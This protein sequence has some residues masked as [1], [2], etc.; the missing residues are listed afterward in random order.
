MTTKTFKNKI[1]DA[2]EDG[3]FHFILQNE[4]FNKLIS[5][6]HLEDSL[7][8]YFSKTAHI[9]NEFE[10]RLASEYPTV[11]IKAVRVNQYFLKA[12]RVPFLLDLQLADEL[13][14]HQLAWI[15]LQKEELKL[16]E[17][18]ESALN[19]KQ[20][21]VIKLTLPE[22]LVSCIR[23]IED[24]RFGLN[25]KLDQVYLGEVY[26]FFVR[27][28][29]PK[30][31]INNI[32]GLNEDTLGIQLLK[33]VVQKTPN[34]LTEL[35]DLLFIW[36]NFKTNI[37]EP[38]C[39]DLA[40][41]PVFE[42]GL[43]NFENTLGALDFWR[44]DEIRYGL[45]RVNYTLDAIH[46]V[47]YYESNEQLK[48]PKGKWPEDEAI[49]RE[50]IIKRFAALQFLSDLNIPYFKF[51]ESKIRLD[52]LLNPLLTYSTNRLYRYEYPLDRMKEHTNNWPDA[53]V[54]MTK[55]SVE[56]DIKI[57]PFLLMSKEEYLEFNK[58]IFD[59]SPIEVREEIIDLFSFEV[60]PVYGFNRFKPGYNVWIKPLL[61]LGNLLFCPMAFYANND[62]FYN[63]AQAGLSNLNIKRNGKEQEET[64]KEMEIRFAQQF[65]EKGFKTKHINVAKANKVD[66]DV[67]IIVEDEH[68]TLFIQLKRP[69][70]RLTL[71]DQYNESVKID[72]KA[73]QQ[74]NDAES[75]FAKKN[76]IFNPKHKPIKWIVS[77]SFERIGQLIHGNRKVNYFDILIALRRPELKTL[78]N[79]IDYIE[80][81][82]LLKG[83]SD[84]LNNDGTPDL[85]KKMILDTG[86]K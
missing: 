9:S 69:Y 25:S 48:I 28:Y 36:I 66:G 21:P 5:S 15:E 59:E 47:E 44:K 12:E 63:F 55:E 50:L 27:L 11:F 72:K 78:S 24:K 26:S 80:G 41:Q 18:I 68:H 54:R 75:Y 33:A 34:P 77:T 83:W 51:G 37:L 42:N 79:L 13:K 64:I 71:N 3:D 32:S 7:H 52:D 17:E 73:A 45:N 56:K 85:L 60:S 67:D 30:Y 82:K 4:N 16:W 65:E 70:F 1:K 14:I 86:L 74:L 84:C 2:F 81:D 58:A 61:K 8:Y 53:F 10:K 62:W 23:W 22:V 49:N 43:L 39:Y 6:P 38:Y 35:F 29:F 19:R 40:F 20:N 57:D 76:K 46:L 31:E